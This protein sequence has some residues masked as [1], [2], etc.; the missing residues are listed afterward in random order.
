LGGR[1]PPTYEDVRSR[2][3]DLDGARAAFAEA[4]L[5]TSTVNYNYGPKETTTRNQTNQS[6]A[7]AGPGPSTQ[8][9]RTRTREVSGRTAQIN[10]ENCSIV[11]ISREERDRR[12]RGGLC[13]R[14]GGSGHFVKECPSENDPAHVEQLVARAGIIVEDDSPEI[15]FVV[16]EET[17][18]VHELNEDEEMGNEN[19]AQD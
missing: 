4:G 6:N 14:C 18:E 15:L 5:N 17:G 7:Q 1:L 12:L 19:G 8:S 2:L 16:D 9:N 11:R 3:L 10:P 13:L